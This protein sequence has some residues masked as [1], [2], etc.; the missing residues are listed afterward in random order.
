MTA[1]KPPKQLKKKPQPMPQEKIVVRRRK[2]HQ[3]DPDPFTLH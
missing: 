2:K 1:R 3:G